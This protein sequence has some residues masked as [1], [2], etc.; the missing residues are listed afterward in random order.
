MINI[1]D[2]IKDMEERARVALKMGDDSL[3]HNSSVGA[4]LKKFAMEIE[5]ASEKNL[6]EITELKE[7]VRI[8][9]D[10]FL[11]ISQCKHSNSI[12]DIFC[13]AEFKMNHPECRAAFKESEVK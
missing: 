7:Q 4:M 10:A 11:K 3:V 8:A 12:H 9:K 13:E 1:K 6:E 2:I 5:N